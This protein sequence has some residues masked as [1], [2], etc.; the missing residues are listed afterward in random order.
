MFARTSYLLLFFIL[1][2]C[3]PEKRTGIKLIPEM[4]TQSVI[5]TYNVGQQVAFHIDATIRYCTDQDASFSIRQ[6]VTGQFCVLVTGPPAEDLIIAC[7][8][9]SR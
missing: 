8:E 1:V 7:L 9:N 3:V 5:A 2:S 6:I 4:K